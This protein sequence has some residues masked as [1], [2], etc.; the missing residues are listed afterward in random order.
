MTTRDR[1]NGEALPETDLKDVADP[2]FEVPNTRARIDAMRLALFERALTEQLRDQQR[3]LSEF[4]GLERRRLESH[5]ELER[6]RIESH[7]TIERLRINSEERLGLL[8]DE[9]VRLSDARHAEAT[10]RL[11][12]T[13]VTMVPRMIKM[14]FG[15]RSH[16]P[17]A[18]APGRPVSVPNGVRPATDDEAREHRRRER[19]EEIARASGM[20]GTAAPS[21]AREP[22]LA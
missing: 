7:E 11:R 14:M 20:N 2:G 15:G 18:T 8:H 10:E 21:A 5:G 9:R 22:G 3:M 16:D 13:V 6:L 17:V 1:A 4:M 19:E 12:K